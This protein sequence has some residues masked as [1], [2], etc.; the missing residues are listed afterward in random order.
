MEGFSY[1]GIAFYIIFAT[2][3]LLLIKNREVISKFLNSKKLKKFEHVNNK[4]RV[5]SETKTPFK[6]VNSGGL[7]LFILSVGP[8]VPIL[9]QYHWITQNSYIL[10]AFSIFRASGRFSWVLVFTLTCSALVILSK[11]IQQKLLCTFLIACLM[12][13]FCEFNTFSQSFKENIFT[14]IDKQT[15]SK[16]N[17]IILDVNKPIFFVPAFPAP[18]TTPWRGYLIDFIANGGEVK[19]FAYMSRIPTSY[20]ISS[21]E[22]TEKKLTNSSFESQSYLMIRNDYY[23]KFKMRRFVIFEFENWTLVEV[24]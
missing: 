5:I 10:N 15:Q 9:G 24:E 6:Y 8:A 23:S 4:N 19:N 20:V 18:D 16:I 3:F 1:P 17:Q 13:Q 14:S 7:F 11:N 22:Q 21:V 2:A 12:L